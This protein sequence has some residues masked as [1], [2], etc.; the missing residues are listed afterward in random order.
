MPRSSRVA[1]FSSSFWFGLARNK[2]NVATNL[3]RGSDLARRE[4]LAI[5]TRNHILLGWSM[6]NIFLTFRARTLLYLT[7]Y[8]KGLFARNHVQNRNRP[9]RRRVAS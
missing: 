9:Y 4:A 2:V 8:P 6:W 3:L 1:R 7:D 5:I